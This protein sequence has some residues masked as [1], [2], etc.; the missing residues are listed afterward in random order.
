MAARISTSSSMSERHV[1]VSVHD[2]LLVHEELHEA[3]RRAILPH[4]LGEK[5]R[6][7][8]LHGFEALADRLSLDLDLSLSPA[9]G[10]ERAEE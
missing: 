6:V 10:P 1:Q 8:G 4:H 7:L 9:S 2:L 5:P 3:L